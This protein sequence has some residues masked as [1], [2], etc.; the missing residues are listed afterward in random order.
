LRGS[1]FKER[2]AIFRI[3]SMP[4]SKPS[5]DSLSALEAMQRMI[6]IG[7]F[8]DLR[9]ALVD[10]PEIARAEDDILLRTACSNGDFRIIQLLVETYACDVNAR[11]GECLLRAAQEEHRDAVEYLLHQGADPTGG[12]FASRAMARDFTPQIES[13]ILAAIRKYND[14]LTAIGINRVPEGVDPIID[15]A[16]RK[17]QSGH[18][19][20]TTPEDAAD[21]GAIQPIAARSRKPLR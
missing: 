2:N 17:Y 21:A 8:G 20:R 18:V 6:E 16:R 12:V 13:M 4:T 14:V 10:N 11:N 1:Y 7:H 9:R 15:A 19:V 5:S 3:N